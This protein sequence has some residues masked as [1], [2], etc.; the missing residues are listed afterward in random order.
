MT[1]FFQ[2]L[3]NF[4]FI[5]PWWLLSLVPAGF[6]LLFL[7]QAKGQNSSWS[8][9]IS[10]QLLPYLLVEQHSPQAKAPWYLLGLVWLL[11]SIALAGPAWKEIPQP[12]ERKVQARVI[13][14][15][16]SLSMHSNDIQPKRYIRA[17]HKL[18]DLLKAYQEGETGLIVYSGDAHIVTPLT[19]DTNTISN[20]VP[21]LMPEIMPVKGSN[22]L[23]AL[24]S[25]VDLLQNTQHS[26]GHIILITDGIEAK[27]INSILNINKLH[28]YTLSI[29]G[30]GTK[31]GAPIPMA[32]GSFLKDSN[33]AIVIPKLDSETL[34]T[35]AHKLGGQYIQISTDDTDIEYL[36]NI[37]LQNDLNTKTKKTSQQFDTWQDNGPW[38]V[39][40]CL[41]IIS[42]AFRKGWFGM[43]ALSCLLYGSVKPEISQASVWDDL[44][45]S[46]DQQGQQA[47][48][49]QD[50]ETAGKLF[51]DKDWKASALYKQGNYEAAAELFAN[52]NKQNETSLYNHANAL[53]KSG[54]LQD[55]QTM[56]KK[57]LSKNPE[58]KDAEHNYNLVSKLLE[59]QNSDQKNQDSNDEQPSS[60]KQ[61]Q[62]SQSDS[63]HQ[64][65]SAQ[66]PEK[67]SQQDNQQQSEQNEKSSE[68]QKNADNSQA[69]ERNQDQANDQQSKESDSQLKGE[70]SKWH[71]K[72]EAERREQQQALDQW[73]RRIPDDPGDLLKRKFYLQSLQNEQQNKQQNNTN[74]W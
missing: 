65:N 50:Y 19:D 73:L 67:D 63:K 30:V 52:N 32:N 49:K 74:S 1:E 72:S 60:D 68:E 24:S 17:K 59:K 6:I 44:W 56:Y 53:A 51:K 25:A 16:L 3:S 9:I 41:P 42:L 2:L 8:G 23:A 27:Q 22:A 71:A 38:L 34:S 18:R 7:W 20:L 43:L 4:H 61:N 64:Q 29:L 33:N 55:A 11:L 48:N 45:T 14:L 35:L 12:V 21:S 54:R 28:L 26:S 10:N 58:H 39:L 70:K 5:R 66:N 40:L 31:E 15:D 57:V 47:F 36:N 13:V 69:E 46:K 37:I 62:E